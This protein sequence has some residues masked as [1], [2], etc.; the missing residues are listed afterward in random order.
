MFSRLALAAFLL[1][2]IAGSSV[3]NETI[4]IKDPEKLTLAATP[5]PLPLTGQAQSLY[6]EVVF[7]DD[8]Y[9]TV[10]PNSTMPGSVKLWYQLDNGRGNNAEK[11]IPAN[12]Q[13]IPV[14]EDTQERTFPIHPQGTSS[15]I[16]GFA[17][18]FGDLDSA[19]WA[20]GWSPTSCPEGLEETVFWDSDG[21]M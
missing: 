10:Q 14:T 21:T 6:F 20:S 15:V 17:A 5:T 12:P 13:Q 16:T 9:H 19:F 4:V 2:M 18:S 1:A 7:G 3:V 8:G 11:W